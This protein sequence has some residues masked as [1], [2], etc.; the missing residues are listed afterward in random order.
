MRNHFRGARING[1][2]QALLVLWAAA[3]VFYFEVRE[4]VIRWPWL[5]R[6]EGESWFAARN[7]PD[8]RLEPTPAFLAEA[9]PYAEILKNAFRPYNVQWAN[10]PWQELLIATAMIGAYTFVGWMLLSRMRLFVPLGARLCLALT[11]GC[12]TVGVTAELLA[13][14]GRLTQPGVIALWAVL[15]A[16]A[17]ICKWWGFFRRH[18]LRDFSAHTRLTATE[19]TRLANNWYAAAHPWP[20]ERPARL[21]LG[22]YGLLFGIITI[23]VTLHAIGEPVAY[24]DSLILYVGYARDIFYQGGFPQKVVGQVGVGLGANY[25]HMYELLAAQ[26]AALCGFWSDTFAQL[27][28]PVATTAAMVLVYYTVTELTRQRLVGLAAAVIV[29]SVP[30]GLSYSQFASNYSLAILFTAA[31]IYMACK[32]VRDGLP[33]YRDLML[34]LAGMAVHINYLMWG[35]WPVAAVAVVAACMLRPRAALDSMQAAKYQS[36]TN[37]FSNA[38]ADRPLWPDLPPEPLALQYRPKLLQVLKSRRF[39]MGAAVALVVASP[40]Y[41]RNVVVTGNPVYAF[42]SNI[43]PSKNV[44]PAVMKSAEQEWLLNGD[45]LGR[46]GRTLPEKLRGSWL[47]FVTGNQ[48]WK[49]APFF[50]AMVLP[51]FLL[52]LIGWVASWRARPGAARPP[53]SAGFYAALVAPAALFCLLWFYA[54]CVA[55]FYL[56]QIIIVLPLFGVFAGVLFAFCKSRSARIVLHTLVVLTALAPGVVMGIMG[57]KLKKTGVYDGMP[58][59][60]MNATALRTLFMK[61]S[62]YYRMEFGGDMIMLDYV[63]ELPARTVILTHENRALLLNPTLKIVHLD[64]WEVQAAYEEPPAER[65]KILDGLGVKYYLYVPNED[66]HVANSWLGMAE[67][68]QLGY[69]KEEFSAPS[70]DAG[71]PNPQR[72]VIPEGKNV[73]YKRTAKAP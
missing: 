60:Q 36:T 34:L 39:W 30:Y 66:R 56:Y 15:L 28:P 68:I 24:W 12:G 67:L 4:G 9:S 65:V 61:P 64:D 3:L 57:F 26:T 47:Y 72:G 42:Y 73:L 50:M 41:I 5:F 63:N 23:L 21:L 48:H 44:N 62:T 40:W 10:A 11:V 1:A 69:Y 46:V 49:L 17:A 29:R 6:P 16:A 70:V 52:W 71:V 38:D 37:L 18:Y 13:M 27:L 2:L 33:A 55:D 53:G 20:Q 7:L 54:Y 58:A 32:L 45:G 25:P 19:Q 8:P 35:L 14:A 43:F 51:G 31:F 59:P 22:L